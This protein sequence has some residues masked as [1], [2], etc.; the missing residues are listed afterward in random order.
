LENDFGSAVT[1]TFFGPLHR[2]LFGQI[3]SQPR[4]LR[5][6]EKALVTTGIFNSSIAK[7]LSRHIHI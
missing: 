7:H 2:L 6:V 3:P 4:Q 5:S 1:N